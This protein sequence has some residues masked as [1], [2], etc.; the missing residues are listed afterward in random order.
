M[1]PQWSGVVLLVGG[2][3]SLLGFDFERLVHPRWT[4][5]G[6]NQALFDAPV[7]AGFSIDHGFIER[8]QEALREFA[9]TRAL[10][11]C[12]PP[13]WADKI[14]GWVPN[15]FHYG[16]ND[17]GFTFDQGKLHRFGGTS[18]YAALNMAAQSGAKRIVLLGYDY[19]G[20]D[21]RQHYHDAYVNE[22][23]DGNL[24]DWG[25]WVVRYSDAVAAALAVRGIEVINASPSSA[26]KVFKKMTIDEALTWAA[27]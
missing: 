20:K 13:T 11:L 22:R 1:W 8:R 18:G 15:A 25:G 12:P 24:H 5:V 10:Y 7:H 16:S 19:G 2:G 9:N 14:A 21:G 17:R 23:R 6:V 3:P 4:V 26:I 27:T